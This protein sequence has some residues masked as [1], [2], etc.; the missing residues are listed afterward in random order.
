MTL[1]ICRL[2]PHAAARPEWVS[3]VQLP[4]GACQASE[5]SDFERKGE[6]RRIAEAP[7]EEEGGVRSP[8]TRKEND[9]LLPCLVPVPAHSAH[10][11]PSSSFGQYARQCIQPRCP[12][13][14]HL[15]GL[16]P[17]RQLRVTQRHRALR[18]ALGRESDRDD[19]AIRESE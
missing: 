15:L 8:G 1:D 14:L 3:N 7:A 10:F 17:A 18:V 19:A 5:S 16:L 6:F 4:R 2:L 11:T 9:V 13:L 12:I